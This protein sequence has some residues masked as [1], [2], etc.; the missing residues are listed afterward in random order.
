MKS[1]LVHQKWY[2]LLDVVGINASFAS[3]ES[4]SDELD[5]SLVEIRWVVGQI[6]SIFSAF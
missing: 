5:L 2:K 3:E 6:G 1:N 4:T